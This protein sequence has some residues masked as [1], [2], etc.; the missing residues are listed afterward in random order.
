MT[1]VLGEQVYDTA[2]VTGSPAAFTP[3]GTVTYEFFTTL[4]GTGTPP[5]QT[6]TLSGGMVPD[7][8]TDGRLGGGQLLV[9]RRLQRRQQLHQ[10]FTGP[11]EPLTIGQGT[12]SVGTTIYDSHAAGAVT[13]VLG[14]KVYDTA[15]V[16]GIPAASRPRAR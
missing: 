7:S 1:S 16:T 13:G 3:T 12:P 10:G 11:V 14:E 9:H 5:H 4:T 2:T 8:A 6:V 15:T